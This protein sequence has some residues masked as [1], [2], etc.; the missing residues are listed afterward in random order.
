MAMKQARM[1]LSDNV[2]RQ[3]YAFG[4]L[5]LVAL[6]KRSQAVARSVYALARVPSDCIALV[7][8]IRLTRTV[9]ISLGH[10]S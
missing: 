1:Y 5:L 10:S 4:G 9:R 2:Y 7:V 6:I 8:L 3:A